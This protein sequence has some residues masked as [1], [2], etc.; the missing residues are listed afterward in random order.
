M[1]ME[2]GIINSAFQQFGIDTAT[3]LKCIKRI[4][5]DYVDV[6]KEAA[7]ISQNVKGNPSGARTCDHLKPPD[8]SIQSSPASD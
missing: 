4:G 6:F 3:G 2:L 7:T 5:F 8:V 1:P